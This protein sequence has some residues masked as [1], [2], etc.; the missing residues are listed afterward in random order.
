M[1]SSVII[2]LNQG[3][4]MEF[5]LR[6]LWRVSVAQHRESPS[7]HWPSWNGIQELHHYF[8]ILLQILSKFSPSFNL[9]L[10]ICY[11]AEETLSDIRSTPRTCRVLHCLYSD[12]QVIML[13][14]RFPAE[15]PKT[16]Y[17]NPVQLL[18][19]MLH[20]PRTT[21]PNDT[22]ITDCICWNH[23]KVT[24]WFG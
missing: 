13:P 22:I 4:W 16:C 18:L 6:G 24:Y 14:W 2:L 23:K 3:A 7:T 9:P 8:K 19:Y 17:H 15:V 21:V 11:L 1:F 5:C 12:L 10:H 20:Q